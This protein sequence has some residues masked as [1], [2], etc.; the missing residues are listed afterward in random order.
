MQKKRVIIGITGRLLGGKDT[1]AEYLSKQ[2]DF[3][4]VTMSDYL[5]SYVSANKLGPPTRDN[6][7]KVAT[8]LRESHG[9]DYLVKLILRDHPD[10]RLVLVGLR[11]HG[12]AQAIKD[13]DGFV[14][15]VDAKQSIRFARLKQRGRIDDNVSFEKFKAQEHHEENPT[16]PDAPSVARAAALADVEVSNDSDLASLY[17]QL[18]SL[19]DAHHIK[20]A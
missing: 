5:R 1:A 11:S 2:Y 18:D 10:Q 4:S 20:P 19:M 6:L 14:I 12:E 8:E 16:D 3:T 15:L 9:E 13:H 7:Y 17:S